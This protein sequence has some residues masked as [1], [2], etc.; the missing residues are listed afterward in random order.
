MNI[1]NVFSRFESEWWGKDVGPRGGVYGAQGFG[2]REKFHRCSCSLIV[3]LVGLKSSFNF[4]VSSV[5]ANY[6]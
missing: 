3:L 6:Y 1:G 2:E 5:K 4:E